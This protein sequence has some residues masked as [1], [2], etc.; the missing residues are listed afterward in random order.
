[1]NKTMLPKLLGYTV[2]TEPPC[3]HLDYSGRQLDETYYEWRVTNV[4]QNGL[5]IKNSGS[6]HSFILPHDAIHDFRFDIERLPNDKRGFLVL[7]CCI[8]IRGDK[9]S[10]KPIDFRVR[11]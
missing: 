10:L 7:N 1:M 4:P 9:V 3:E 2:Q 5:S 6:W 8:Q 11:Q